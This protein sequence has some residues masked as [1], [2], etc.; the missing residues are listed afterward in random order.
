MSKNPAETRVVGFPGSGAHPVTQDE[1]VE[2]QLLDARVKQLRHELKEALQR[3]NAHREVLIN[4]MLKGA[5]IEDGLHAVSLRRMVRLSII[6]ILLT[7]VGLS[8]TRLAHQQQMIIRPIVR[9]T[10]G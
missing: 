2:A 1:I 5:T 10:V 3:R 7:L 4:R 6:T 9:Q 8:P